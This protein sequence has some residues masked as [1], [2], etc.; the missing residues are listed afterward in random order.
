MQ[1]AT[2]AIGVA[3][4]M[5][6]R[7]QMAGTPEARCWPSY[8]FPET[9]SATPSAATLV[10][11]FTFQHLEP[12]WTATPENAACRLTQTSKLGLRDFSRDGK[13]RQKATRASAL[14]SLRSPSTALRRSTA[15]E[16]EEE[17]D[18]D[19]LAMPPKKVLEPPRSVVQTVSSSDVE[20]MFSPPRPG[21][22]KGASSRSMGDLEL[23]A[24]LDE[25][26][27]ALFGKKQ[28]NCG[29]CDRESSCRRRG[30]AVSLERG[31]VAQAAVRR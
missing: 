27:D 6:V 3:M 30:D 8:R 14:C 9:T 11:Q 21:P 15:V 17:S 31:G 26:P 25:L 10:C 4:I 23:D 1:W 2:V 5:I 28:K 22:T 20:E 18:D 16:V 24:T 7:S 29:S 12:R 13:S 19:A